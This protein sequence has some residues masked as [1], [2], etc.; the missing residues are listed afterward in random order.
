MTYNPPYWYY[1]KVDFPQNEIDQVIDSFKGSSK[2]SGNN[3]SSYYDN[4][5][6][7]SVWNDN[8]H[9]IVQDIVIQQGLYTYFK[10]VYEY[11]GQLYTKGCEHDWHNH[12]RC[13]ANEAVLSFV[14]WIKNSNEPNFRF[15]NLDTKESHIPKQE[16]GDLIVFPSWV[17]HRVT[18]NDSDK[19][20][21]VIAGNIKLINPPDENT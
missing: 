18:P 17:F 20:R 16:E 2:N 3:Y 8:Y 7:I 6:N 11:W 19:K 15:I 10:Y 21:F 12:Y 13:G 14:H 1:G 9:N 4:F 5:T